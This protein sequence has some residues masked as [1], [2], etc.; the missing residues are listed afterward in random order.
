MERRGAPY[1]YVLCVFSIVL[2]T[3]QQIPGKS[4]HSASEKN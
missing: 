4:Q 1:F 3:E 2:E